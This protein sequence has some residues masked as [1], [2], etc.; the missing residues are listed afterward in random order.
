MIEGGILLSTKEM[1]L[2]N[3]W[4][5]FI[6]SRLFPSSCILCGAAGDKGMDLCPACQA[7][8][9]RI[10]PACQ[11]CGMPL[12]GDETGKP[13]ICGECLQTPPPFQYTLSPYY[14]Q[15]PLV[16]LITQFKFDHRLLMARIFAGLLAKHLSP[17]RHKA[18]CI[19]PVPLHPH[20]LRE[21]GYNQSLEIARLLGRQ[22]GIAVDYQLCQ[23][24]RYTA[25]Q[26]GL[27]AKER[28]SNVKNAFGL[29]GPCTYKHVV[30][31]DDVITTGHTVTELAK[32]LRNNG[33]DEIEVW[34]LAR[35]VPE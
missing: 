8:L 17:E 23:R 31:V 13:S 29:N 25:P 32:L 10:S 20:R 33:V 30:I 15:P 12:T 35:A 5:D 11:R 19:I 4:L 16:Q 7:D 28:K 24:T 9:S 1:K 18:E 21:R 14:Y 6:H 27:A 26:T 2:V 3:N 34:S 22:V